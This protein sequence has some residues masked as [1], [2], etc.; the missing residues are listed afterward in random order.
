MIS[1]IHDPPS[2]GLIGLARDRVS[3]L[4]GSRGLEGSGEAA[5]TKFV[6]AVRGAR[7]SSLRI[8]STTATEPVRQAV[9]IARPVGVA[10]GE[11]PILFEPV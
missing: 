11:V 10:I 1:S 6:E 2:T 9:S 5:T 3:G 8:V 7:R 4:G